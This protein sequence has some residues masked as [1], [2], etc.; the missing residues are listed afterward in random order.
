M[1][2][3][4]TTIIAEA[5]VN[6]NGDIAIARK[7]VDAAK[8][9]GCDYIKFQTFVP[10]KIISHH[11]QKAEYQKHTTGTSENQLD[12]VRKVALPL[13]AFDDL[14]AYCAHIELPCFSTPFDLTS[15]AHLDAIG[16]KI[17]RI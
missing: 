16:M 8:Q 11:A 6:H 1:S 14:F 3:K 13:S 5:G 12:M 4:H 7:L 10:E 17:W 2:S 15:V 9:T